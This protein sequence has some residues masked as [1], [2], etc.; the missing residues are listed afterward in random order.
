MNKNELSVNVKNTLIKHGL[1]NL[2]IASSFNWTDDPRRMAFSFSRYK[3]VAKMFENKNNVLEIGCADGFASRIVS[4]SVIKLSGLDIVDEHIESA[5]NTMNEKW[6][7]NF[8][9]HDMLS[10]PV[11]IENGGGTFDAAFSLD[12]LEHIDPSLEEIFLSNIVKSL[13][14][15]SQLI[16]GMPSLESQT[17]ASELS[18]IGHINCKT[19]P[20]LKKTMEKYFKH[21]LMFCFNDEVLHTGYHKMS[22]YNIAV[23]LEQI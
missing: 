18:K 12:V 6:P 4:Q 11:K 14:P 10:G 5:K 22:H 23:C 19:Q 7:I 2:G 3:F 21:V 17:Y 16:I 20:D 9:F 13:L 8:F 1:Q 15:H